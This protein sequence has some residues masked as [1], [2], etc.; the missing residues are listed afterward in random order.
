MGG[1]QLGVVECCLTLWCHFG[2][3]HQW[4][5]WRKAPRTESQ[6]FSRPAHPAFPDSCRWFSWSGLTKCRPWQGDGVQQI[7]PG[8]RKWSRWRNAWAAWRLEWPSAKLIGSRGLSDRQSSAKHVWHMRQAHLFLVW[9]LLCSAGWHLHGSV[10]WPMPGVWQ[11]ASGVSP[12][13]WP[14]SFLDPGTSGVCPSEWARNWCWC[15][16][17]SRR[18]GVHS[19]DHL[20]GAQPSSW[21]AG[22]GYP[23]GNHAGF[24]CSG[25]CLTPGCDWGR[26][27]C[28]PWSHD[29]VLVVLAREWPS[30]CTMA[31]GPILCDPV[32]L[33]STCRGVTDTPDKPA[34]STNFKRKRVLRVLQLRCFPRVVGWGWLVKFAGVLF[35]GILMGPNG[36]GTSSGIPMA[37]DGGVQ[38]PRVASDGM[39]SI[40]LFGL[41]IASLSWAVEIA[42]REEL[43]LSELSGHFFRSKKKSFG[44]GKKMKR[45]QDLEEIGCFFSLNRDFYFMG[46]WNNPQI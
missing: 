22:S 26:Y 13:F 29:H 32:R 11:G 10:L 7:L 17:Y 12:L 14:A 24:G 30:G 21:A 39:L 20:W 28:V 2:S 42:S 38:A 18:W 16:G 27:R 36:M 1:S 23:G 40:T 3:S 8:I 35:L 4:V 41:L 5:V 31:W 44:G 46:V 25:W 45:T 43:E 15:G 34:T 33:A 37:S 6:S 9:G 19:E